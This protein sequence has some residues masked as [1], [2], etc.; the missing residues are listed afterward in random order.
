[1]ERRLGRRSAAFLVVGNTMGA[2]VFT[3]SDFARADRVPVPDFPVVPLILIVTTVGSSLM[4][5]IP[6]SWDAVHSGL[7][8]RWA[9]QSRRRTLG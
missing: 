3:T 6:C 9:E 7:P 1:M 2:G 5:A 8:I 4:L